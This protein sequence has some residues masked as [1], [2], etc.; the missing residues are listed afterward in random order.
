M[1]NISTFYLNKYFGII[2]RIGKT[3]P[4]PQLYCCEW[5]L[6]SLRALWWPGLHSKTETLNRAK[7]PR[8][9]PCCLV[10]SLSL[11]FRYPQQSHPRPPHRHFPLRW[12]LQSEGWISRTCQYTWPESQR[13]VLLHVNFKLDLSSLSSL[14]SRKAERSW[15]RLASR[16]IKGE[17]HLHHLKRKRLKL[18]LSF[19]K[20]QLLV[21]NLFLL[22]HISLHVGRQQ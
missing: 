10:F 19:C 14:E 4:N 9:F 20:I 18:L 17:A 3:L 2:W 1:F 6:A 21:E 8:T 13:S 12:H 16:A 15:S 7:L 5:P 11:C 22:F